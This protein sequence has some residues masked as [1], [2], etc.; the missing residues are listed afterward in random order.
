MR[1][2]V[3]VS[4]G[5]GYIGSH[6][7]L[8]L[9]ELGYTPVAY[10]NLSNGHAE[11]VQWGPLE[12]G[13]IRDPARLAEV[14]AL[15]RPC[16]VIHL[17]GLIE[18]GHSTADPAL[19]YDINVGGSIRLLQAA[20]GAGVRAVVF[21]S[22]CAVYGAPQQTSI[23]EAH[24]LS[25]LNPYGRTKLVVEEFLQELARWKGMSSLALRYF[26]A[27]GADLTGRI[28]ERHEP[29]THL[30]PLAIDAALG[31]RGP[32]NIFGADYPTPDGT[33]IRDYIHVADLA[34]AHVRA[35]EWLLK[36]PHAAGTFNAVNLGSGQGAS[37]RELVDAVGRA[38]GSPVPLREAP[39][40]AGDASQLIADI[41]KAQQL[42]DW[43]PSHDLETVVRTAVQWAQA[44]PNPL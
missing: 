19:F 15:H 34:D 40:R 6:I 24:P 37:V 18:V 20:E 41:T 29:E 13:D 21:S 3:L 43:Q 14:F 44:S 38:V 28:G 7:C 36:T 23:G 12:R 39:R 35:V 25:P 2:S 30:I 27:A 22:S 1:S 11:F 9:A 5:A 31:R 16:A 42:L 26:N 8:R 4:G 33:A 17:A 10:D 32:L